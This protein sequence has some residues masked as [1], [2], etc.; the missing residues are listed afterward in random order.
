MYLFCITKLSPPLF[1][2]EVMQ[3]NLIVHPH[4]HLSELTTFSIGGRDL[5][6][7]CNHHL[8]LPLDSLSCTLI[9]TTL[10]GTPDWRPW[11]PFYSS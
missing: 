2:Q 9:T 6:E 10:R 11:R 7:F 4:R 3:K 1:N 8:L 5:T